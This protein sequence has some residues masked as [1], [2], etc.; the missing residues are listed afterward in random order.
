MKPIEWAFDKLPKTLKIVLV[1]LSLTCLTYL[2]AFAAYERYD[3]RVSMLETNL[4][5]T[6]YKLKI[7]EVN[8]QRDIGEIKES[9]RWVKDSLKR[10]ETKVDSD[11]KKNTCPTNL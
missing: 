11:R 5:T 4:E 8:Q 9:M 6:I 2:A 1:T 3:T 10:I 7:A